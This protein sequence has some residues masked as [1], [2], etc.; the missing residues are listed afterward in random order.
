MVV[1]E[2]LP[3]SAVVAEVVIALF[4]MRRLLPM[5][6]AIFPALP[7]PV[8]VAESAAC[9]VNAIC[10][11]LIVT[12]PPGPPAVAFDDTPPPTTLTEL[13]ALIVM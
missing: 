1:I 11:E 5:T 6:T 7:A 8:L 10:A 3:P 12:F 2:M 13:G 9:S 4:W